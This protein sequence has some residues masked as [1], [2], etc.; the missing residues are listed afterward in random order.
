MGV[1]L[2]A[3]YKNAMVDA[4][5]KHGG[6]ATRCEDQFRVG[7]LDLIFC[8]RET[9]VVFAEAKRFTGNFFEP[10]LRQWVEMKDIEA[11]GGIPLLI[12]VKDEIHHLAKPDLGLR[13]QGRVYTSHVECVIQE[14]GESFPEVFIRWFK[15][16]IRNDED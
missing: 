5:K 13:A 4:I 8:T 10:R 7:L 2:E 11:G 6:Y 12:G 14:E 3:D 16:K 1:K 15:E 9:G